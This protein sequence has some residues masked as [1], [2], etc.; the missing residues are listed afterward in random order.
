MP[1]SDLVFTVILSAS[2]LPSGH[3]E[4]DSLNV[5]VI[6]ELGADA[7]TQPNGAAPVVVLAQSPPIRKGGGIYRPNSPTSMA[8]GASKDPAYARGSKDPAKVMESRNQRKHHRRY[9]QK[10]HRR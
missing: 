2:P 4:T 10:H 8:D 9:H 6:T 7:I 1:V 3:L 5:D